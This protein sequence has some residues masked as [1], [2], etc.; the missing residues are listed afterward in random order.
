MKELR[1]SSS[2]D[3][4]IQLT[5]GMSFNRLVHS[6]FVGI[7]RH[8]K[9]LHQDL[10]LFECD[11]YIWVIP[12]VDGGDHYFLKTAYPSRKRTHIHRRRAE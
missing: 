10:M 8:E 1:W 7:E 12:F 2:K 11:G 3:A 9:R 4:T 5:R 6:R